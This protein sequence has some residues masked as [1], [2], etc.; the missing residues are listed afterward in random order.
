MSGIAPHLFAA[1]NDVGSVRAAIDSR[2]SDV[3][4]LRQRLAEKQARVALSMQELR[5]SHSLEPTNFSVGKESSELE[6][7]RRKIPLFVEV[8]LFFG[9]FFWGI[10]AFRSDWET[11]LEWKDSRE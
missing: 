3:H 1:R 11:L 8:W 10:N 7:L 5:G 2:E 6:S 4:L 9:S